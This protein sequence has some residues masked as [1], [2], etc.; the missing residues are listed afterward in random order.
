MISYNHLIEV[1]LQEELLENTDELLQRWELPPVQLHQLNRLEPVGHVEA[2]VHLQRQRVIY[3]F[4]LKL[5]STLIFVRWSVNL[6][7][8]TD[9]LSST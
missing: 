9:A 3:K 6:I 1:S 7:I 4:A 5:I 8:G 2:D